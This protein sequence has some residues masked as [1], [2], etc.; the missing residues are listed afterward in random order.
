MQ[1]VCVRALLAAGCF[2]LLTA[3]AVLADD[4]GPGMMRPRVPVE[5]LAEA[6]ALTNPTA[7]S[8]DTVAQG[9]ALY[10]GKAACATCHGITGYGDG[11]AAAG[12]SPAPRNFHHRGFW[13]HRS[14]GEL[15]WVV[16]Y[17][18]PGTGMPAFGGQLS[19]EEIWAI[20]RYERTFGA[21]R[22]HGHG[23]HGRGGP[24]SNPSSA[25]E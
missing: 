19:D 3:T 15:F 12:L 17:G 23:R 20:L 8:L 10:E 25:A 22:G 13:R 6:R 4:R 14:E 18:I 21:R 1:R 5:Q 16:K 9:K 2:V 7:D 11:P 24:M